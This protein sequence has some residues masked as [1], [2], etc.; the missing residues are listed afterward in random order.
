MIRS[1]TE[2]KLK[3]L[4]ALLAE[5]AA[6]MKGLGD[7]VTLWSKYDTC[8]DLG[9]FLE[10]CVKRLANGNEEDIRELWG[11]FAPTSDWDDSGGSEAL[12]NKIFKLLEILYREKIFE[13]DH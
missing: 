13:K 10:K 4:I 12:A 11:I 6:E 8:Q 5:A 3:T 9:E 7:R 2:K 1:V